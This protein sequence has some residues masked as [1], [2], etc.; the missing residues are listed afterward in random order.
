MATR[1]IRGEADGVQ[2]AIRARAIESLHAVIREGDYAETKFIPDFGKALV[3]ADGEGQQ[4]L[5]L[6]PL[7]GY[8]RPECVAPL[9]A[10]AAHE[11]V[12]PELRE[13][14]TRWADGI[15]AGAPRPERAGL[16]KS[17]IVSEE[18]AARRGVD[19]AG[20]SDGNSGGDSDE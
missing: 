17:Q 9:R 13:R 15:E 16:P 3:T 12:L 14:A 5:A 20:N 11:G 2:P 18:E 10:Y 4:R 1:A 8:W 6:L 19:G 7:E